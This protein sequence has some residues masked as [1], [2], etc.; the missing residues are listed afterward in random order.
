MSGVVVMLIT[1]VAVILRRRH[2]A[3][4]PGLAAL[5]MISCTENL[6]RVIVT[7]FENACCLLA[8]I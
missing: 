1:L 4:F 2:M 5:N 3:S 7:A 6:F 8:V